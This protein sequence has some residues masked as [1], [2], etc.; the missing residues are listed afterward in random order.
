[1]KGSIKMRLSSLILSALLVLV[2]SLSVVAEDGERP[3]DNDRRDRSHRDRDHER[4]DSMNEEQ[5]REALKVL[6][7][8]DP[9]K[10]EKLE[11]YIDK[12]PER[13]GRAIGENFP[14]LGRFMAMRRYDP[15]GFELHI[16]DLRL[17]RQSQLSARRLRE[18][19]DDGDDALA[20][21]ELAVLQGLVADHFDV[22]QQIR[23]HELA[24]LE[25]QIEHLREQMDERATNRDALIA[26]R[27]GEFIEHDKPDRW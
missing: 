15:V 17:S 22:R 26:E 11:K 25:S 5:V 20:A 18:A 12:S 3:R 24:K 9:E 8:I 14:H 27:V 23:E 13:V 19:T 6:R 2:A 1:M 10:A 16:K 7:L 21:A 4:R